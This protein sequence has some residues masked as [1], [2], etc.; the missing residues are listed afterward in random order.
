[1]DRIVSHKDLVVWQKAVALACKVYAASRSLPR[2][3]RFGL[4]R[5]LRR[6]AVAVASRIAEGSASPSRTQFVQFLRA[7]RCSL[8]ELET[9][10]EIASRLAPSN[11]TSARLEEIAE[12]GRLLN[13]LIR[14]LVSSSRAAHAKAC[15]PQR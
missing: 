2:D 8:S 1:M 10:Y 13:G 14:S 6:T 5:Q 12:V 7:S 11:D 4:Q 15:A 9:L 3:G